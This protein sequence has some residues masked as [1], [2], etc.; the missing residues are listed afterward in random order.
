MA[1]RIVP[2]QENENILIGRIIDQFSYSRE[3]KNVD[4]GGIK[5]DVIK[6]KGDSLLLVETKK[7]SRAEEASKMQLAFYLLKLEDAGIKAEGELRYP[8]ERK[9]VS[10][11]LDNTTRDKLRI[12]LRDISKILDS[13][14]PPK[15]VRIK[16]C[17][18]CGYSEFCWA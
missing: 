11:E 3:W 1:N 2:D 9:R 7:S 15:P 13:P 16:Y 14:E 10:V 17:N 12:A 4:L 6:R 18:K 8:E 5:F